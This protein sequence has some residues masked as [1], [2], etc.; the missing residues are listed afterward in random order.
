MTELGTP[1]PYLAHFGQVTFRLTVHSDNRPTVRSNEAWVTALSP[2]HDPGALDDLRSELVRGLRI[3]LAS[4][5]PEQAGP[6]AEDF[7]QDAMMQILASI[8]SF[9]GESRFTTWAH[10]IAVRIAITELRRKRWKD[11]SLESLSAP[12]SHAP[13][14]I[15]EETE[16]ASPETQAVQANTAE[17]VQQLIVETL[18]EKQRLALQAVMFQGVPLEEVAR[19]M[20]TSRNTLYKLLHDARLRLKHALEARNLRPEDLLSD[21]E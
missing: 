6:L 18:T 20:G 9:R 8:G 16:L 3:M 10:K 14:P 13:R 12:D 15:S 21:V 4:R 11:F 17:I 19:R 1:V 2:P 7:A 5:V